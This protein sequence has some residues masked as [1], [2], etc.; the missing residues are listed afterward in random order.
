MI[1]YQSPECNTPEDVNLH[2]HHCRNLKYHMMY[3]LQKLYFCLSII[4]FPKQR[5]RLN[6]KNLFI[7]GGFLTY[8]LEEFEKQDT[9]PTYLDK[10]QHKYSQKL[11]SQ[12]TPVLSTLQR[13]LLPL[14]S[15]FLHMEAEVPTEK[16]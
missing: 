7:T 2:Q 4:I 5:K 16:W 15:A 12:S 10:F 6:S 3:F 1:I 9:V 13:N 14:C 8:I 11:L